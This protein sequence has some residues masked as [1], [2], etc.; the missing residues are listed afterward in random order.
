MNKVIALSAAVVLTMAGLSYAAEGKVVSKSAVSEQ[1]VLAAKAA[2]LNN[3]E[4]T[5]ELMS[6][7]G[8]KAK[9]EKDTLHFAD[10]KISSA[11]LGKAGY[12][13]S[14]FTSRLLEDQTSDW[15][16]MQ[17]SEKNGV[18]FWRGDIGP[19]GVMRGV[20]SKRDLKNNTK[21]F[22]FV[23]TSSQKVAPPAPAPAA[24]AQAAQPAAV[25]GK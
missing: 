21:D 4:W 25:E 10:G 7:G 18:A 12:G 9:T 16:T 24:P 17:N 5:I 22:S 6:M 1:E 23:S 3:T 20:L 19:D 8:G 14:N 13:V 11:N 2:E 15:E